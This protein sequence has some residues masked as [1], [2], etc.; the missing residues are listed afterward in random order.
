[1]SQMHARAAGSVQPGTS[2]GLQQ[3]LAGGRAS[4]SRPQRLV[5]CLAHSASYST[6]Q[7][8]ASPSHTQAW[9]ALSLQP[10]ELL[11]VQQSLLVG[12][13]ASD[14]EPAGAP[15]STAALAGAVASVSWARAA[16]PVAPSGCHAVPSAAGLDPSDQRPSLEWPSSAARIGSPGASPEAHAPTPEKTSVTARAARIPSR[17]CF[18]HTS[19]FRL[20]VYAPNPTGQGDPPGEVPRRCSLLPRWLTP[21]LAALCTGRGSARGQRLIEPA[22]LVGAQEGEAHLE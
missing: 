10:P 22:A 13:A 11:G 15:A 9:S 7:Q 6:V 18:N 8:K 4:Q 12:A 20:S 2:L 3:S 1:M 19:P 21:R 16:A 14:G 5:A 17:R